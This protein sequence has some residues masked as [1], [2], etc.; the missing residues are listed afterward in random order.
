MVLSDEVQT[1]DVPSHD[2]AVNDTYVGGKELHLSLCLHSGTSA[3]PVILSFLS[4][5]TSEA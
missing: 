1:G 5:A 4:L 3:P 2:R